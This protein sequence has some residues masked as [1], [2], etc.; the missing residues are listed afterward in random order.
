M[1][2]PR[3]LTTPEGRAAA[4]AYARKWHADNKNKESERYKRWRFENPD[5]K[6]NSR[7]RNLYGIT[8]EVYER[9]LFEQS[10]VCAI[11]SKTNSDGRRLHVDHCHATGQVRGLLCFPCN[12]MLGNANDSESTLSLAAE[13]LARRRT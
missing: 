9:M 6:R 3:N 8:L 11:C 12:T 7:L 13:Y 5:V 10:G 1:T 4:N 2:L